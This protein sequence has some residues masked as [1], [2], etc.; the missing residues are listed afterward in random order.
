MECVVSTV[1]GVL[2]GRW[3]RESVVASFVLKRY[4]SVGLF[5]RIPL[6]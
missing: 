5:S 3:P 6:S 2:S 1:F 4:V